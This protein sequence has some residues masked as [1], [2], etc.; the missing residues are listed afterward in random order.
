MLVSGCNDCE[1]SDC[2]NGSCADQTCQCD[3]GYLGQDCSIQQKP[4]AIR[5]TRVELEELPDEPF[6]AQIWDDDTSTAKA[7]LP[8]VVLQ[9]R[10]G[11][12]QDLT[13]TSVERFSDTEERDFV[14]DE[15]MNVRLDEPFQDFR[16]T[17][18]D[19]DLPKP[20]PIYSMII[21]GYYS[22]TGGFPEVVSGT[23]SNGAIYTVFLNYEF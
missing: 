3:D 11:T 21:S 4:K 14:F 22:P 12:S 7:Y 6:E 16:L 19:L 5:I 1:P 23:D 17:V 8:D 10:V 20:T 18:S 9:I 13:F 15:M 2:V